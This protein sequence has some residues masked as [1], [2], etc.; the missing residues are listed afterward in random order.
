VNATAAKT[1]AGQGAFVSD[2]AIAWTTVPEPPPISLV[3]VGA[4]LLLVNRI[5]RSVF[6]GSS[7]DQSCVGLTSIL[8][9]NHSMNRIQITPCAR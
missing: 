2:Y 7:R 8:L 3:A 5:G 6:T 1:V 9:N 4:A